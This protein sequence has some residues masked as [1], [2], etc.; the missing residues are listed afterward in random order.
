MIRDVEVFSAEEYPQ[1]SDEWKAV[2]R[3]I[4]TAS[5]FAAVMASG[6]DGP[7][8]T[9]DEYLRKLAGELMT[10]MDRED[11]RNAAMDRGNVMEPGLRSLYAM[12]TGAKPEPVGFVK[13]RLKVG[14][15]GC[16]PDS[17]VGESKVVEYKS[18][19]PHVLIN[20][21]R[22]GVVP[23]EYLPQCQGTMLVTGRPL[24]DI[25][26]GNDGTAPGF[27][28]MPPLIRTIKRDPSYCARLELALETFNA[29][30]EELVLWLRAYGRK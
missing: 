16:S 27:E 3:G 14:F 17:F 21:L 30:L 12:M 23:P 13:G 5:H 4:P 11:Y 29:D 9:R 22:A 26:I 25:V 1:G 19:A 6:R 2:R 28:G 7:S 20:F 24:C 8:K 15:A 18:A 10:G